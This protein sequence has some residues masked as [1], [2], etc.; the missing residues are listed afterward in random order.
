MP[1]L[2]RAAQLQLQA[3]R[4][5]ASYRARM[6]SRPARGA[7]AN[8]IRDPSSLSLSILPRT[9]PMPRCYH[10]HGVHATLSASVPRDRP[11][12]VVRPRWPLSKRTRTASTQSPAHHLCLVC[13]HISHVA[14]LLADV[15][16]T[17]RRFA[18]PLGCVVPR[19]HCRPWRG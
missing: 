19:A 15:Q 8:L 2:S 9:L 18:G 11:R 1:R 16:Y 12:L 4:R 7:F 5:E 17:P 13:L 14:R 10:T 3:P 6:R